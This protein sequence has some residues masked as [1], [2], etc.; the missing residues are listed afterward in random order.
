MPPTSPTSRSPA[1][2]TKPRSTIE[3][4]VEGT[5]PVLQTGQTA[6]IQ[7]VAYR[8]DT[9]DEARSV[10][11][12]RRRS[13]SRSTLGDTTRAA[14]HRLAVEGMAVGGRRQVAVPFQLA[15]GEAGNES[16][17][18]ARRRPTWS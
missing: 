5:G 15:F 3:D 11:V 12:G 1:R 7:I 16:V 8:A 17:R 10:H 14:G 2:R 4:L 18:P 13:R 6:A 9:G